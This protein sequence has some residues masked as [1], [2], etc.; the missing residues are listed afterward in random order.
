MSRDHMDDDVVESLDDHVACDDDH[1]TDCR[2]RLTVDDRRRLVSQRDSSG[3]QSTCF[4]SHSICHSLLLSES[5]RCR[6]P[7]CCCAGLQSTADDDDSCR[8][9]GTMAELSRI[10][11]EGLS[12]SLT[13]PGKRLLLDDG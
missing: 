3:R 7:H 8:D 9:T 10:C 5:R 1:S 4:T 11:T 6:L 2:Y 13:S 12:L